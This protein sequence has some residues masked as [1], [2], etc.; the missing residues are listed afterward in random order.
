MYI[1]NTLIMHTNMWTCARQ[2]AQIY[3]LSSIYLSTAEYN[4]KGLNIQDPRVFYSAIYHLV[5]LLKGRKGKERHEVA[6]LT[7]Y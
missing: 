5:I 3:S 1:Y 2:F 6:Y 7:K 4:C